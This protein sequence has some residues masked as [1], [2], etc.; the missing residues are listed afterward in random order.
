M[1]TSTSLNIFGIDI[2]VVFKK[3]KRM[4]VTVYRFDRAN[5]PAH[6]PFVRVG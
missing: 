6:A 2:A 3:V 4:T 1:E 5:S